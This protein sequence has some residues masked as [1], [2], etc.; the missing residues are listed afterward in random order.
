MAIEKWQI[1]KIER[2][3]GEIDNQ[4]KLV[5]SFI[6]MVSKIPSLVAPYNGKVWKKNIENA[7]NGKLFPVYKSALEPK[8]D[9]Y[10]KYMFKVNLYHVPWYLPL[11]Y[12][13]ENCKLYTQ[14]GN[15]R[16][17]VEDWQ[18][19]TNKFVENCNGII[20]KMK[21]DKDDLENIVSEYNELLAKADTIGN[22]IYPP[23]IDMMQK[24]N[25]FFQTIM[26]L[27]K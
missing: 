20:T 17:D 22:N 3:K 2:V 11:Y 9:K 27:W 23:I 14:A 10:D 5:E 16:I 6:D 19:Q 26:H 18:R 13:A 12:K 4:T 15:Y 24:N 7:I 21:S 1:S 8:Y 25:L